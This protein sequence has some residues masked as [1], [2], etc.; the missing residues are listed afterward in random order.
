MIW[1]RVATEVGST[2]SDEAIAAL[3]TLA[4]FSRVLEVVL[5]FYSWLRAVGVRSAALP[6]TDCPQPPVKHT[7]CGK[8]SKTTP[9]PRHG[10]GSVRRS[11]SLHRIGA[12]RSRCGVGSSD[13]K[14]EN[15]SHDLPVGRSRKRAEAE[16][17]RPLHPSDAPPSPSWPSL[18]ALRIQR[19]GMSEH[20]NAPFLS[21]VLLA[22]LHVVCPAVLMDDEVSSGQSA[23]RRRT[24]KS[25][26]SAADLAIYSHGGRTQEPPPA[27]RERGSACPCAS[28]PSKLRRRRKSS[29]AEADHSGWTAREQLLLPRRRGADDAAGAG[30][31]GGGRGEESPM[32]WGALGAGSGGEEQ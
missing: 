5:F 25:R 16:R 22:A 19:N 3:F 23:L 7:D 1:R 21:R 9:T 8:D 27:T 31:W 24:I 12:H 28:S 26:L 2:G 6:M 15:E 4:P 18:N 14:Q 17:S 20:V 29:A 11:A 30:G 13:G 10:R 32:R